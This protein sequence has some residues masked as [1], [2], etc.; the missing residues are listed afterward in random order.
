MQ[1]ALC[2]FSLAHGDT[3]T[4][5][6]RVGSRCTIT[7]DAPTTAPDGME[8]S[9]ASLT[10]ST[11]TIPANGQVSVTVTNRLTELSTFCLNDPNGF[12]CYCENNPDELECGGPGPDPGGPNSPPQSGTI[13]ITKVVT[14]GADFQDFTVNMDCTKDQY[15][16]TLQIAAGET[17]T[18]NNIAPYTRCTITED[19]ATAPIGFTYNAVVING[20]PA[21]ITDGNT[22]AVT[23]TN[24]LVQGVNTGDLIIQKIVE[25]GTHD[26]NF[27]MEVTCDHNGTQFEV[28][29]GDN[30]STT[31]SDLPE[32]A[33]CFVR[34]QAPVAPDGFSYTTVI[35]NGTV[36]IDSNS[37]VTV[38]VTNTLVEEEDDE[39]S[40]TSLDVDKPAPVNADNDGSG[41]ITK[42]DVLTYTITA[43]NTGNVVLNNVVV[44]DVLITPNSKTCATLAPGETCVLVG[45]HAVT[46]AEATT[47][48]LSNTASATSAEIASGSTDT[49]T[50][51]VTP[52]TDPSPPSNNSEPVDVP[53]MSEWALFMLMIMLGIIGYRQI[54]VRKSN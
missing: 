28:V 11:V 22:V 4:T 12:E 30:E 1:I 14:G 10:P 49:V 48:T 13:T 46:L 54:G 8:F 44:S 21:R 41:D 38:I 19:A 2:L 51:N 53:T 32:G 23:V 20:S 34:E 35:S 52:P 31:V 39:P 37:S 7:E 42:D 43:T 40:V 15:D 16:Q 18:I 24:E 17:V 50:S 3:E 45:T 9:L 36:T 5:P 6:L 27:I 29:V 33:I 47:G 26:A 25:G